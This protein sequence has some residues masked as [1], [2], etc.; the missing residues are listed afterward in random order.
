MTFSVPGVPRLSSAGVSPPLLRAEVVD[1]E[2][3]VLLDHQVPVG[4]R[5]LGPLLLH[6]DQVAA[7]AEIKHP[8]AEHLA[9]Y[10]LIELIGE[11]NIYPTI[12][13]AVHAYIHATGVDWIDWQDAEEPGG[14]E[15]SPADGS[16][17]ESDEPSRS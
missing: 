4:P 7:L 6:E 8:V 11:E 17:D 3:A 14:V 16:P 1:H 2:L 12:G 5:A 13:S 10:G 9:R 15:A